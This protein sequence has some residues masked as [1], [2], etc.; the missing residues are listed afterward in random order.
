MSI[1]FKSR[2]E[3]DR[4]RTE[5]KRARGGVGRSLRPWSDLSAF[6]L[7]NKFTAECTMIW[8]KFA[9]GVSGML[10]LINR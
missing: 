3:L 10:H 7:Q 1:Q 2:M 5:F 8:A 6:R 4:I 9:S